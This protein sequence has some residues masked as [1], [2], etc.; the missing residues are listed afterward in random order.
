[1]SFGGKYWINWTYNGIPGHTPGVTFY[2]SDHER[3]K[4]LEDKTRWK[5][6]C[7]PSS[8][9]ETDAKGDVI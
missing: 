3:N 9:F 7:Y 5:F 8:T 1:M 4:V 2:V 6:D